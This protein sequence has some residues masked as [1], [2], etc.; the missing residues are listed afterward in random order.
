MWHVYVLESANHPFL[1]V[2]STNDV[3][4]RLKEHNDGLSQSTAAYRP[5]I[6]KVSISFP[7][8]AHARSLERYLKTGS[9]RAVL[10]KRILNDEDLAEHEVRSEA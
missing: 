8:E 7:D 5:Y 10:K 1:Y 6:L 3:A 4:R 9:G 2:G